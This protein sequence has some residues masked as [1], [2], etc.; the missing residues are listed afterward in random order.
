MDI[1]AILEG[2][3]SSVPEA[4][5]LYHKVVPLISVNADISDAQIAEV[6]A[7]APAVHDA[8]QVAHDAIAT[9]V[10]VHT[11]TTTAP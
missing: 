10:N 2:L 4:I 8:V 6:N 9:L 3:I 7:L 11:T 5:S 1:F